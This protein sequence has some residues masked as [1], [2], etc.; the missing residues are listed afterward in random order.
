MTK[1]QKFARTMSIMANSG[2]IEHYKFDRGK[3]STEFW[4]GLF[5]G[6]GIMAVL[7]SFW[8]LML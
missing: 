5:I 3:S 2:Q 6:A 1:E 8:N 7:F 4:S